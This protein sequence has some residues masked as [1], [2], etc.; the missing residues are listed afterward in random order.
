V[1]IQ[2][3]RTIV[4]PTK[5]KGVPDLVV[6]ILSSSTAENDRDRKFKLYSQAGIPEYWIVDPEEHHVLQYGLRTEAYDLLGTESSEIVFKLLDDVRVD[7]T[8]VW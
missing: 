4:T 8:Q 1:I 3:H 5:I 7:L 6:E 2:Q